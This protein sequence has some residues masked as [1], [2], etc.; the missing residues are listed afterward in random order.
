[1]EASQRLSIPTVA[2][3]HGVHLYT[4]DVTKP[5]S[6]ENRRHKK[7]NQFD[8]IIATNQL[9]KVALTQSGVASEKI[10][11][12]GSA[13]YCDEWMNQNC[14]VLPKK[15][16]KTSKNSG[17]LKLVFFPSKPQ[18]NMDLER[19]SKT[20][21]ILS[22]LEGIQLMVKPHTRTSIGK[23]YF[24]FDSRSDA[25]EILTAELCEWADAI[26][27]VGSSV[28][29]EALMRNKPALYLKYMHTNTTLFDE[30]QACWTINDEQELINAVKSLINNPKK[31]PYNK[32]NVDLFLSETVYGGGKK[33]DILQVYEQFIVNSS[34][35]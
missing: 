33:K 9:R 15:S 25:T 22:D 34:I 17:L 19:M 10:S 26:L 14:K 16:H 12:L 5:K 30:Y 29:T 21:N 1:M 23:E 35:A 13:R 27:V 32:T 11:V 24:K 4:N 31:I 2:L 20:V 18:C 8:Y 28:I 7:F 6:E 3:P